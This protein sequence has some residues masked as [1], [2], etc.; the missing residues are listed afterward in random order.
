MVIQGADRITYPI[1]LEVTDAS[2]T[3][4]DYVIKQGGSVKLIHR[5]PLKLR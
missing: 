5:T 1:N 2:K 3:T 4:I